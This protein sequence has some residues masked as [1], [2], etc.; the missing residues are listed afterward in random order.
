M[1]NFTNI[2]FRTQPFLPSSKKNGIDGYIDH[3]TNVINIADTLLI[4]YKAAFLAVF[5]ISLINAIKVSSARS[6]SSASSSVS[7][8]EELLEPPN[9]FLSSFSFLHLS[10]YYC[11]IFS[12]TGAGFAPGAGFLGVQVLLLLHFS[13]FYWCRFCCCWRCFWFCWWWCWWCCSTKLFKS[14]Y[15]I[16]CIKCHTE[17]QNKFNNVYVRSILKIN[18]F[19]RKYFF[20]FCI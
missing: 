6:L 5:K 8:F 15:Y 11:C 13:S 3:I 7:L 10:F 18:K 9:S 1:Q 20:K 19:F 16:T 2:Y 12:S 14:F 17:K 4:I